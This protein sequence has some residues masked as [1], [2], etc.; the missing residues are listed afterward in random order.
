MHRAGRT[1]AAWAPRWRMPPNGMWLCDD[2]FP[3]SPGSHTIELD[4]SA[5]R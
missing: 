2:C 4:N 3:H 5:S 1:C